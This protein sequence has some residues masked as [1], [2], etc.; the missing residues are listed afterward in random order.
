MQ[1]KIQPKINKLTIISTNGE[2]WTTDW[3][4]PVTTMTLSVDPYNHPIWTGSRHHQT[5]L[6]KSAKFKEKFNF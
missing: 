1:G 2:E 5:G 4:G 3:C 6:G